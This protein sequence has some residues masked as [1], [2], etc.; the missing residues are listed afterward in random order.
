MAT[1]SGDNLKTRKVKAMGQ[2]ILL[3][4]ILPTL[5]SLKTTKETAIVTASWKVEVFIAGNGRRKNQKDT[6][7][8]SGQMEM[9]TTEN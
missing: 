7:F 6:D 8:I 9:N 4:V 2:S 5:G 3:A 1:P